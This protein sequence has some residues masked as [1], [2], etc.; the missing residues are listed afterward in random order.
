MKKL[1]FCL[2]A[3]ASAGLVA[4]E[5]KKSVKYLFLFI[6]DGMSVPQRMTAEAFSSRHS[7]Y[8]SMSIAKALFKSS[9]NSPRF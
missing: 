6:G 8:A 3:L 2:L 9:V 1:L 7:G 4:Q 5:S